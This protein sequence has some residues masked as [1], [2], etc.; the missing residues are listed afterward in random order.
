MGFRRYARFVSTDLQ[1]NRQ[2]FYLLTWNQGLFGEGLLTRTWGRIGS[3]GHSLTTQ[4]HDRHAAQP[5]IER[6]IL[7]R[8]RRRYELTEWD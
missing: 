5:A 6:L 2:R 7:R 8:I 3:H 4:Y 1:Q